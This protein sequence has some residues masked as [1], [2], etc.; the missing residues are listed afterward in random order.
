MVQVRRRMVN[1]GVL[2]YC[3]STFSL[4][5]MSQLWQCRTNDVREREDLLGDYKSNIALYPSFQEY[6]RMHKPPLFGG[7][8]QERSVFCAGGR[9]GVQTGQSSCSCP[10]LRHWSLRLGNACPRYRRKHPRFP[11]AACPEMRIGYSP[12][13]IEP[14]ATKGD[15]P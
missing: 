8:G 3:T 13:K 12:R 4:P 10:L 11:D 6:F 2:Y 1:K 9:R 14:A 7:V 15:I 5:F